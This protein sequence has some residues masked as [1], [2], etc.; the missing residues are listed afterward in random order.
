M[1][2]LFPNILKFRRKFGCQTYKMDEYMSKCKLMFFVPSRP[3][4]FQPQLPRSTLPTFL[5]GILRSCHSTNLEFGTVHIFG[6][7]INCSNLSRQ[8]ISKFYFISYI[9]NRIEALFL[10]SKMFHPQQPRSTFQYSP[11][12]NPESENRKDLSDRTR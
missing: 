5:S 2:K 12:R 6:H 8:N 10:I 9:T 11:Q 7:V 4:V 3:F 1:Q